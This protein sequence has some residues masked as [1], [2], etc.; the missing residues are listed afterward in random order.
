M[1]A[2]ENRVEPDTEFNTDEPTTED[3]LA[4]ISEVEA[5]ND[6]LREA[7]TRTRLTDWREAAFWLSHHRTPQ[8]VA[9][10]MLYRYATDILDEQPQT[11]QR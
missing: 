1:S 4:H 11:S 5:E 10:E 9:A 6:R 2:I 7:I 8:P 3:M